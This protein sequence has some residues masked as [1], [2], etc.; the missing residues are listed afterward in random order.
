MN[1][2]YM[3]ESEHSITNATGVAR[4]TAAWEALRQNVEGAR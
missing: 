3:S 4:G 2:T 1:G